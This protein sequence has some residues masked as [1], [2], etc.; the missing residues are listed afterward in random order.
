[1]IAILD[2]RDANMALLED[3]NA[4]LQE[5]R[6]GLAQ[7]RAASPRDIQAQRAIIERLQ[8]QLVGERTSQTATIARIAA[9]LS[10]EKIGQQ[11]IV[12]RIEAE[13][14]GQKATLIATVKRYRAE[15]HN[16][17]V[18][19]G[20][21]QFLYGQ[22]AISQQERDRRH[23][24]AVTTYDQLQEGQA[25]LKRA[26][27]T[28][29]QQVGEARANQV[30]TIMTLQEQLLEAKA[31]RDKT[32]QTLQK[33]IVEEHARLSRLLEVS[34]TDMQRAQAQINDAAALMKKAQAD[35]QLSYVKA[36]IPG[37]VL[38]IYTKSGE[39]MSPN[40]IVEV[41][42]TDQMFVTA[43]I[44]EDSIGKVH[45]GQSATV[46]SDNGAFSGELK[47]VVAEVGRKIG[48]KDVLNTDPAADVDA[49][50]VEVKI[51]LLPEY[52]QR[53]S[54]L[55]NAK[56]IVEINTDKTTKKR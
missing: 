30:K 31:T 22:G 29:Q 51:A 46:T 28:L 56:V 50:V 4:K 54:G 9:Q 23:L 5:S 7:I 20:R 36:P 16:A 52:S 17:R 25:S 49:R 24:S 27:Q 15:Q 1:V 11:A 33:Q 34:P 39:V 8:A 48:K 41:G 45:L 37:E 47:G 44:P 19:D 43:E 53:V 55:T 12:N 2:S 35:L 10:G 6:A 14:R 13:L 32:V 21:Y 3:T 42:Q 26:I 18:D 40:G 38:K